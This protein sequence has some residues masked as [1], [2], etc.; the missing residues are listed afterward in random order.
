MNPCL[1]S[2]ARA[3]CLL[4][5]ILGLLLARPDAYAA[6][7]DTLLLDRPVGYWKLDGPVGSTVVTNAGS[8]GTAAAGRVM[9]SIQFGQ[10]GFA[11]T[12]AQFTGGPAQIEIPFSPALNREAFTVEIWTQ[13][14]GGTPANR[15]LLSSIDL[16]ST[17]GFQILATSDD[18]WQFLT[19]PGG[20]STLW[21]VIDGGP[22]ARS[23]WN[24]LVGQFDGTNKLF[25][26][27]G[28]LVGALRSP[29]RANLNRPLRIGADSTYAT[30]GDRPFQGVLAHVA[31][32]DRILSAAAVARHF[33]AGTGLNP[34]STVPPRIFVSP[35][36]DGPIS[37]GSTVTLSVVAGGSPNLTYEWRKDGIYI[38]RA[39]NASLTLA[40]FQSPQ[41]GSYAVTIK[42]GAG[43]V[44]SLPVV[45]TVG[46]PPAYDAV[47]LA[48]GP[49]NYWHLGEA[50]GA[51]VVSDAMGRNPGTPHGI[52]WGVP[53]IQTGSGNTGARCSWIAGSSIDVSGSLGSFA[54]PVFTIELW[55][56]VTGGEGTYRSP[57]T[58][59]GISPLTGFM[60]Y[61][62][63][64]NNWAFWTGTG[65]Y[66]TW[67]VIRGPA[68]RRDAWDH[69]AATFDGTTKRF[70]VNGVEVGTSST[71]YVPAS[72]RPFRVGAGGTEGDPLYF[73]EG[74]LDEVAF[75][76]KALGP[77]QIAAHFA[78]GR[79]AADTDGPM[80]RPPQI[81]T[82]FATGAAGAQVNLSV[83]AT[84][85]NDGPVAVTL[86]HPANGI[87]PLG[88]TTVRATATD[89]AGN[90]ATLSFPVTVIDATPPEI[91]F[92][93]SL[94][95][96][97]TS[98]DGAPLPALFTARDAVDGDVPVTLSPPVGTL[99][100]LGEHTVRAT[101]RDSRGNATTEEFS[102]WVVDT[103]APRIT[104]PTSLTLPELGPSGTPFG[105]DLEVEDVGSTT[106]Q[107]TVT[108][109]RGTY[110][111]LG[112]TTVRVEALDESGN[113][114]FRTFPITVV[115]SPPTIALTSEMPVVNEGEVARASGTF[116]DAAGNDTVNFSASSGSVTQTQETGTWEWTRT[117]GASSTT[118]IT[119][120]VF[121]TDQITRQFVQ[122]SVVV[123]NL[124]P[125]AQPQTIFDV[126]PSSRVGIKL[127]A[128][129]PGG[130]PISYSVTKLPPRTKGKFGWI[131][132]NAFTF[133][134]EFNFRGIASFDFVA[135]D[136]EGAV[137]ASAT[138]TLV[139][140]TPDVVP[141]AQP[142]SV[143]TPFNT[144]IPL[145]LVAS[146]PDLDVLNYQIATPP[147]HGTLSG[148]PPQLTYT[149]ASGFSG[150]DVFSFTAS[151]GY[152]TS[153]PA[154]VAITVLPQA[155]FIGTRSFTNTT[156]IVIPDKG[157]ASPYGSPI[158]VSGFGGEVNRVTV[159]LKGFTHAFPDDV[160]IL[161][162]SPSGRTA[163]I[164]SDAGGG[165]GV[166]SLDFTF[167]DAAT[168][169][170]PDATTLSSGTFRPINYGTGDLFDAPAPAGP[171]YPSLAQFNH[172]IPNGTW[173]LFVMDDTLLNAGSID[174][175]WSLTLTTIAGI[176]VATVN[177][178]ESEGT[179]PPA[180]PNVA[181]V[182][183]P[184]NHRLEL[185][186]TDT[187]PTVEYV[188]EQSLD[189]QS[190]VPLWQGLGAP[191][192]WVVDA[193][194]TRENAH[195][196]FRLRQTTPPSFAPETRLDR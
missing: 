51:T 132:N 144:A 181:I 167:T 162:V 122:F 129:D 185:Q 195:A 66:T 96:E 155:S 88:V 194:E 34:V 15:C 94:D 142:L 54:S 134:P 113:S 169:A 24:H 179:N 163:E 78:A 143:S 157:A 110:L 22:I 111:P 45:L 50:E 177:E 133:D 92:P 91:L 27:N 56:K 16:V 38:S 36:S 147:V 49:A 37:A 156:R 116:S 125:V 3:R 53:G 165:T 47:A 192:E 178:A 150:T 71:P 189:L 124:P 131:G 98:F 141:D 109:P 170:F 29:Y 73:F 99:L 46:A 87:Y 187:D 190:W 196:F 184:D 171:Y 69:L 153:V 139:A 115:P 11:G 26:V 89:R 31:V 18:R 68:V 123:H 117:M 10:P 102:V 95:V 86:D 168:V 65:D 8:A 191:T 182:L 75:Y 6:Y 85:A 25:Y 61:A 100:S 164:Q 42:N 128:T 107:I 21:E 105:F 166:R 33:T 14:A 180:V 130:D 19:G 28:I 84:D 52:A 152:L 172:T 176:A 76:R 149:P 63:P 12:S 148:T 13:V 126:R 119:V 183:N 57:L 97:A 17:G 112:T 120:R 101:T 59:R 44:T 136:D 23:G 30:F 77:A 20:T 108:P 58:C 48:D 93:A 173:R 127:L 151:D 158:E 5:G 118:P 79:P 72:K 154:T 193:K 35:A 138:V 40:N 106:L 140:E 41:N 83:T 32:Y 159:Q 145:S 146:D 90:V 2:R 62:E 82:F 39:V 4:L 9:G 70:Y 103:T 174:G 175:G 7:P 121:A 60:F 81:T 137:S 135:I 161:L 104:C 114:S 64:A 1:L 186:L 80:I 74:D 67:D 160:D 188:L 55:A 43:T